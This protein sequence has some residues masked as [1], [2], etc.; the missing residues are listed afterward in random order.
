MRVLYVLAFATVLMPI[1]GEFSPGI[2][3]LQLLALPLT[4]SLLL[5]IVIK[6]LRQRTALFAAIPVVLGLMLSTRLTMGV[7]RY[8]PSRAQV[9]ITAIEGWKAEHGRF[10]PASLEDGSPSAR[11]RPPAS[12]GMGGTD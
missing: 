5:V 3:H 12:T 4:L 6:G 9:L 11:T 10:P 7:P 8:V 1:C 2:A